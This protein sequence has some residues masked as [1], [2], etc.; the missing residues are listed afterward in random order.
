LG[1]RTTR[2]DINY[3]SSRAP[4][5]NSPANGHVGGDLLNRI[6]AS[7]KCGRVERA[8]LPPYLGPFATGT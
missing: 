5:K 8:A 6:E 3:P 4:E 2:F 7:T 1:G